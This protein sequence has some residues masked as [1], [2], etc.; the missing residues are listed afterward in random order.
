MLGW[1]NKRK[2]SRHNIEK[3]ISFVSMTGTSCVG[4]SKNISRE[5]LLLVSENKCQVNKNEDGEIIVNHGG[6]VSVF[7]GRVVR[8][9]KYCVDKYYIALEFCSQEAV[10]FFCSLIVNSTKC[11]NCGSS[12]DLRQCPKCKGMN[13]ICNSCLV[14]EYACKDCRADEFLYESRRKA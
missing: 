6:N 3:H 14:R 7:P 5:A 8:A 13:T 10:E 1:L 2:G 9:D 12:E 11:Y 4:A